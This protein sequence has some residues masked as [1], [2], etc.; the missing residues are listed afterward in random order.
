MTV[1]AADVATMFLKHPA[2]TNI[3]TIGEPTAGAFSNML[4][5][6]LPNG[7]TFAFS[8]ERYLAAHDGQNYE[9]TGIPP[10]I[11]LFQDKAAFAQGKD[12]LLELAI[13][14]IEK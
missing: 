7:W 2:L 14:T 4:Q 3:T 12:N 13:S 5:K 8:N 1:S 6:T 9:G 11:E 10:D